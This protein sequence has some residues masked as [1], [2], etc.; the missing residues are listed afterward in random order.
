MWGLLD[1]FDHEIDVDP[2]WEFVI[3][4]GPNGVGKTKLLE[5]CQG[6]IRGDHPRLRA[7]PFRSAALQFDDGYVLEADRVFPGQDEL[8]DLEEP[9]DEPVRR[10]RVVMRLGRF[11]EQ[12][13]EWSAGPKGTKKL[14]RYA[15]LVDDLVP[16][17]RMSRTSW[18][19]PETGESISIEDM[20]AQYA[21]ILPDEIVAEISPI[22]DEAREFFDSQ[23]VHLISTQRLLSLGPLGDWPG[24]RRPPP[25]QFQQA[26][27]D[28][29]PRSTV[30]ELAA[31]LSS[32]IG[33]ALAQNSR[34]SQEQDKTFPQRLLGAQEIEASELEVRERYRQQAELRSRLADVGVL[35]QTPELPL[36][37]E[38]LESWQIRV[39]SIYLQDSELKLSNFDDLLRK[40]TLLREVVNQRFLYKKMQV[41]AERGFFFETD[42]G[43]VLTP[44]QLSSGEQHEVVL[45]YR[46]LFNV[47]S[48]AIVL[49]DEPEISLHIAWQQE[50]L[51]DLKRIAEISGLQFVVATHSPHIVHDWVDR[52][53]PLSGE[54]TV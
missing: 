42:R 43:L 5:L 4:H 35:D 8:F 26:P 22:P 1:R 40:I 37:L 49:I 16:Y 52:M 54:E 10:L 28:S 7:L 25:R 31:D 48:D 15:E 11:G 34:I 30:M 38:S 50:V 3:L 24:V 14:L 18:H 19:D 44:A 2:D 53:V 29:E 36:P 39:M 33:T 12:I 47:K 21:D 51:N 41:H 45:L 23:Q 13:C 32:R 46:L 20:V 6:M 9:P 27:P 17:P